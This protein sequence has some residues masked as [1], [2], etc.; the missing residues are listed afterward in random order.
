MSKIRTM[1]KVMDMLSRGEDIP[2]ALRNAAN[3]YGI[4]IELL[5]ELIKD[6]NKNSK[7][8]DSESWETGI[9]GSKEDWIDYPEAY[10]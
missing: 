2:F 1:S 10:H 9:Y 5:K 4:N 6:V 8:I 7:Y 3:S